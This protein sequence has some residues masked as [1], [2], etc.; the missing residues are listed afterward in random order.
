MFQFK[1]L[2]QK[3]FIKTLMKNSI[4][5]FIIFLAIFFLG[6]L[7]IKFFRGVVIKRFKSWTEKTQT[8]IDDIL[9]KIVQKAVVPLLYYGVFYMA[10]KYLILPKTFH[11]VFFKVGVILFILLVI[12]FLIGICNYLIHLYL[13]DKILHKG[14]HHHLRK[15]IVFVNVIIWV[16]GIIFLLDNI[17]VKIFSLVAG[18]GLSTIL[19]ALATKEIL[20]DI[21][22]FVVIYLDY[23]FEVGDFIIVGD[24]MGVVEKIGVKTTRLCS[25]SGEQLILSNTMLTSSCISNFK[26]MTDRRISFKFGVTYQTP[27]KYLKEIPKI[28][29][30][31]IEQIDGTRFDR[32]HF[33]SHGDF[34]YIFEIVYYVM[35]NDYVKYM[36]I[37]EQINCAINEELEK[38]K[39]Q[40]AYP[41]QTLY[42]NRQEIIMK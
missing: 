42:I 21:F 30:N 8:A 27:L 29:Q 38:R 13:K 19:I 3:E 32:A 26:R 12:R 15:I 36:D 1:E 10:Q 25:L 16:G 37:Q 40:L 11:L 35:G 24:H 9:I 39:V 33:A 4:E 18:L 22:S 31:I 34:S 2:L 28:V 23:P 6:I 7:L 41:T 5:D 17:G 20:G 14:Q